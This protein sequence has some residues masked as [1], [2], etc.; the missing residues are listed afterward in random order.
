MKRKT[1]GHYFALFSATWK[2]TI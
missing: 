2:L 1:A